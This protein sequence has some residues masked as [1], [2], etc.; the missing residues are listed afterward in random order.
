MSIRSWFHKHFGRKPKHRSIPFD[1]LDIPPVTRE[2]AAEARHYLENLPP[3]PEPPPYVLG[4]R[5]AEQMRSLHRDEMRRSVH[6]PQERRV[7]EVG[8]VDLTAVADVIETVVV[9]ATIASPTYDPPADTGHTTYD[10][11]GGYTGGGDTGGGGGGD[12]GGGGGG[13]SGC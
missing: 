5:R 1:T 9:A 7:A 11:G 8:E 4:R 6:R 12:G 13:G 2:R 10:G 3:P